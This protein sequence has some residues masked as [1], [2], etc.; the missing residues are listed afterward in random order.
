MS[1]VFLRMLN[2]SLAAGWLILAV[3][4]LRLLLKKAPRW[5]SCLL[6]GIVAV[7]LILPFSVESI[8]SLLPSGEVIPADITTQS[9]PVIDSGISVINNAVNPIMQANF[10]PE[11]GDSVNPLQVVVA[12]S[13]VIWIIGVALM[14]IYTLISFLSLKRQVKASVPFKKGS[15]IYLCDEIR[16][17]FIIGIIRPHIYI[18]SS[19]DNATERYVIAHENAH[20]KRHDHWWKPLGFLLLSVYWFNPL[21]WAA[22][23]LLC[24]DIEAACDEKVIRDKNEDYLTAYSQAL[25]DCAIQ[26]K[27]ISACPLAFG[28]TGVKQRIKNILNYKKPAFWIIIAALTICAVVAVCFLTDP[29]KKDGDNTNNIEEDI[30]D[31]Y[32]SYLCQ[33]LE[34]SFNSNPS[35]SW[36]KMNVEYIKNEN[37]KKIICSPQEN[38]TEISE[39]IYRKTEEIIKATLGD[40]PDIE[41]EL[42]GFSIVETDTEYAE[43][44]A[45]KTSKRML[46]ANGILYVDT[47]YVSGIFGRCGMLDGIITTVINADETPDQDGE[48][49]F[50][51]DGWQVGFEEDTIDVRIDDEYCIFA[52]QGSRLLTEG[53]IPQG[54]LQFTATV[55]EVTDDGYI[56]VNTGGFIPAEQFSGRISTSERFK[57]SLEHYEPGIYVDTPVEGNILLIACKP[58]IVGEDPGLITGVYS[59]SPIGTS[60][61]Q[62]AKG[63]I[64]LEDEEL[65]DWISAI[66]LPK[67]YSFGEFSYNIGYQGG[68][69]ILPQCYEKVAENG[70]G[71]PAQWLYSGMLTRIPADN[72]HLN[73]TYKNGCPNLSGIMQDN[74]TDIKYVMAR[75]TDVFDTAKWPMIVLKETHDLYTSPQVFELEQAGIDTSK[76]DM[77]SEYWYFWFVKEDT[78]TY[79]ILSLTAK[80]FSREEAIAIADT[81]RFID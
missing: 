53:T 57:L 54:V 61:M 38:Q 30:D 76:I 6:W 40:R 48:A 47:G 15:R 9:E 63:T 75:G 33:S 16:T 69:L 66:E 64:P 25:L 55:Q 41:V 26:R 2:M 80:E 20:L 46:M 17:P 67:G 79:Y 29:A 59:I 77:N 39:E 11:I 49:N 18:P 72:P 60:P 22:Y 3:I 58:D 52:S 62:P 1:S 68:F 10:T 13:S 27:L 45:V 51:A 71:T 19:L 7:R 70:S 36:P 81:V 78:D 74:H 73:I 8:L 14:L 23:I 21:C 34:D 5:I 56:I 35:S 32:L 44:P 28:E 42:T 43:V 12:V 50:T 4:V 31:R 24:R 65:S 37:L